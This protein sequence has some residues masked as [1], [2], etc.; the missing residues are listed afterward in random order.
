MYDFECVWQENGWHITNQWKNK[1]EMQMQERQWNREQGHLLSYHW[2]LLSSQLDV[3]SNYQKCLLAVCVSA[4]RI[5]LPVIWSDG[6]TVE[7]G[8]ITEE[9]CALHHVLCYHAQTVQN[10]AQFTKRKRTGKIIITFV[11]CSCSW[12]TVMMYN[13]VLFFHLFLMH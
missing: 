11:S 12:V 5:S 9:T 1:S 2:Y 4:S 6:M 10:V 7:V 8:A 13:T 3:T